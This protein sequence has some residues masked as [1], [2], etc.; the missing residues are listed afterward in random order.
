MLLPLSECSEEE[1]LELGFELEFA[2]LL[3]HVFKWMACD[4]DFPSAALISDLVFFYW[5]EFAFSPAL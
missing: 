1:E 4:P 5:S 2:S 3:A